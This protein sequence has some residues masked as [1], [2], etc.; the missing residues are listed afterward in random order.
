MTAQAEKIDAEHLAEALQFRNVNW[1]KYGRWLSSR[2][3]TES[4]R[5]DPEKWKKVL[6]QNMI[7]KF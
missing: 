7:V 3:V 5:R 1:E 2:G 6:A 4:R